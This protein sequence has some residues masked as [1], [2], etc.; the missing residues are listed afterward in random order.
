MAFVLTRD[1]LDS[2]R[3]FL[4]GEETNAWLDPY[5]AA[6]CSGVLE[7]WHQPAA[8]EIVRA[9]GVHEI[10]CHSFCHRPLGEHS[11]SF[12]GA[13]QELDAATAAARLKG[14]RFDTFVFPRNDVGHLASLRSH[15]FIGYRQRLRRPSGWIGRALNLIEEFN[16]FAPP[17]PAAPASAGLV[18]I[19][20]GR[21][22]NWQFGAR[23]RVPTSTTLAR[24]RHLLRSAAATGTVVH[25]WL[26]PHNLITGPGTASLLEN[27]LSDVRIMRDSGQ[28]R[29]LTQRDYCREI[30][31]QNGLVQR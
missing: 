3:D 13:N 19:P 1:E 6:A 27:V 28:I 8:L 12:E 29:V 30:L 11:I 20:S 7:G 10:A 17:Q 5:R 24:W 25:L 31:N 4:L 16:T 26:H 23:S 2:L 22:L 18:P 9:A 14:L 21:F 15:G